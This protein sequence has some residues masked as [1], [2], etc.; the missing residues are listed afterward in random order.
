MNFSGAVPQT[1]FFACSS[2]PFE[3]HGFKRENTIVGVCVCREE[4]ACFLMEDIRKIWGM[5]YDFSSLAGMPFAGKTGFMKMQK[6]AQTTGPI[7]GFCIWPSRILVGCL[8][9]KW[10]KMLHLNV[11]NPILRAVD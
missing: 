7:L 6:Y 11:G 2:K 4:P 3:D 1:E 5:V 10:G 8:M 9:V